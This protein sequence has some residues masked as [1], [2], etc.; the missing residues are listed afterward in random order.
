MSALFAK[1]HLREQSSWA[2]VKK[3]LHFDEAGKKLFQRWTVLG[4]PWRGCPE[5]LAEVAVRSGTECCTDGTGHLHRWHW[6]VG[7]DK[8]GQGSTSALEPWGES[9]LVC[10]LNSN[11][12]FWQFYSTVK[13]TVSHLSSALKIKLFIII[14]MQCVYG[15]SDITWN[16]DK[17]SNVRFQSSAGT[18][19]V[20]NESLLPFGGIPIP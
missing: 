1:I 2:W 17:T 9:F 7:S 16:S 12:S 20:F 15:L 8:G 11:I 4:C 14:F 6:Q 5:S 3:H 13:V 18:Q 19:V 10:Q